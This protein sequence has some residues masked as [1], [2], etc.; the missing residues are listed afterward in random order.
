ME[1]A[2]VVAE[3]V[4]VR[5]RRAC[6]ARGGGGCSC[7]PGF[8]AQVWS[9]ADGKPIRRTFASVAEAK[10]WR[11]ETQVALRRG[12]LRAPTRVTV[13]EV[14]VE[15]LAGAEAGVVRTRSGDRYK[16]SALRTYRQAL[17]RHILPTLGRL[18]LSA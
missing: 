7:R 4:Q 12:T 13:A 3:G 1:T 8:Q 16:P 9:A 5:H 10:R 14:A 11:A 18:R 15:W 2:G 17:D 6:A